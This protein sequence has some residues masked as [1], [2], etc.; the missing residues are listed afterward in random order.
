[1]KR[2]LKKITQQAEGMPGESFSLLWDFFF[3][4]GHILKIYR[5]TWLNN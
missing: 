3:V 2:K 4:K 5:V 1:M